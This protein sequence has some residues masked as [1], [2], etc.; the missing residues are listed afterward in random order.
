MNRTLV[1]IVLAVVLAATVPGC[2]QGVGSGTGTEPTTTGL[3]PGD[4]KGGETA[5]F[6][7]EELREGLR[8]AGYGMYVD[9]GCS[10]KVAS[11]ALSNTSIDIPEVEPDDFGPIQDREGAVN[12]NLYDGPHD[13]PAGGAK[14]TA[15]HYEGEAYTTLSTLNA[16]CRITPDPAKE[17]EQIDR[18]EQTLNKLAALQ[19]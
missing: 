14:V 2:G 19:S 6:T 16:T 3:D 7:V 9:P 15:L 13:D 12:C 8:A 4:C 11:W 5:P 1:G 10:S 18:L 17:Q